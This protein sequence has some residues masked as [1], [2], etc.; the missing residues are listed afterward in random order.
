MEGT[1]TITY[2]HPPNKQVFNEHLHSAEYFVGHR[3]IE[4]ERKQAK[5]VID[6]TFH[7]PQVTCKVVG[8]TDDI[9]QTM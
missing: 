5:A 7:V 1:I 6:K 9:K 8:I 4:K 2:K 3:H